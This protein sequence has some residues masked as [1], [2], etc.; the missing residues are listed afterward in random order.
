[1]PI[2][3]RSAIQPQVIVVSARSRR[4]IFSFSPS[5]FRRRYNS[6]ALQPRRGTGFGEGLQR[7]TTIRVILKNRLAPVAAILDVID[8]AG[9]FHSEFACHDVSFVVAPKV[10]QPRKCS[11]CGT[12]P[13]MRS[14]R[15]AISPSEGGTHFALLAKLA[16]DARTA[17]LWFCSRHD[18]TLQRR[19]M[20]GRGGIPYTVWQDTG[21][22]PFK[23]FFSCIRSVLE[24]VQCIAI[25]QFYFPVRSAP[26]HSGDFF[27][28]SKK[29]HPL[30]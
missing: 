25:K 12:D 1:V 23:K 14:A 6:P 9:I 16:R 8:R 26:E 10:C 18:A 20:L 17:S 28:F 29:H 13:F 2:A 24:L 21:G 30:K 3:R 4:A 19:G 15:P 7:A 5:A 27:V 22:S 11:I